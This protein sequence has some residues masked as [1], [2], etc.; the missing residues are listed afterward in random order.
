MSQTHNSDCNL[1]PQAIFVTSRSR[2]AEGRP[3][4]TS[5]EYGLKVQVADRIQRISIQIGWI[6]NLAVVRFLQT[7]FSTFHLNW[8]DTK[9]SQQK[10]FLQTGFSTFPSILD[11]LEIVT[12]EGVFANRIKHNSIK[13]G[14]TWCIYNRSVFCRQNSANIHPKWMEFKPYITRVFAVR[15]QPVFHPNWMDLKSL[16][17]KSICRQDSAQF[18][19]KWMELKSLQ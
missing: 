19:L 16:Q 18:H 1:Y 6:Q 11:G 15:I 7:G 9:S 17:Y 4:H 14:W 13:L 3:R 10:I 5:Y 12:I 2:P 8:M